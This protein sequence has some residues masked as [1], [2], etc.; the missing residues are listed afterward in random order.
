MSS[1]QKTSVSASGELRLEINSLEKSF[2]KIKVLQKAT[3]SIGEKEIVG[4][5][6]R[7]GAG[8]TT[9]IRCI[10]GLFRGYNGDIRICGQD[11]SK[12]RMAIAQYAGFMLEPA[13]CDY[14]SAKENLKLLSRLVPGAAVKVEGLLRLVSLSNA[15]KRKTKS[16]S[17]G[18]KQRLGLAEALL[19]DA[20]LLV[21]D[22]PFV[23]LDP[24][25]ISLLKNILQQRRIDGASILFSSHQ[26]EDVEDICDR[27]LVIDDG[28]ITQEIQ[29]SECNNIQSL[30]I[31]MA[32]NL[33]NQ[34]VLDA[35]STIG[36]SIKENRIIVGGMDAFNAILQV[37]YA[38]SLYPTDIVVM[39]KG[40]SDVLKLDSG[41]EKP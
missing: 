2:G 15:A 9:L 40:L 1:G 33:A 19:N 26:I 30:E 8:K 20:P 22:E 4:L 21:L 25:G 16:F 38:E 3:L 34:A 17:F 5:V 12:N 11:I 24:Y 7:N 32:S 29:I 13:F 31:V 39:R 10:M 41:R 37:L 28:V 18:M 35:V 14:L 6:G 36:C 27:V 23:G